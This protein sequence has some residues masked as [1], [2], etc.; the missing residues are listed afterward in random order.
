MST[1]K[2]SEHSV[3]DQLRLCRDHAIAHGWEIAK[4]YTDRAITGSTMILRPGVQQLMEAIRERQV[5][6]V[7]AESLDRLSRDQEDIAHIYKRIRHAD[8]RLVT[9]VEGEI[10]ELHI[11]LKGTMGAIFLKDLAQKT[12]RG[13]EGRALAGKSAG[14]KCYGYDVVR[15]L[16]EK[17]EPIRGDRA[18]NEEQ[19]AVIVRI[20]RDFVAGKSAKRIAQDLN[21]DGI[22]APTGDA[23]GHSTIN[24]NRRRGN[25]ILNNELY[26]GRQIWNRQRFLKHPDTGKREARPNPESEWVITEIPE[27]R[28]VPQELW[29]QVK[30]YQRELDEKPQFWQKQRPK[31]LLSG[32]CKCGHCGGG[33]SK[34]SA[35]HIGCSTARNKGTCDNRKS[36]HVGHLEERVLKALRSR[37]MEPER[38]R[39]FC[40]EYTAHMNRLRAEHNAALNGYRAE[41]ERNE[42]HIDKML[43]AIGNGLDPKKVKD[44]VNLLA[45]RQEELEALIADSKEAPILFHPNMGRHYANEVTKLVRSLNQEEHRSEAA[46]ILRSLIDHIELTFDSAT[47]ELV[48]DLHGD[49]A[50]ILQIASTG[51]IETR[52]EKGSMKNT[53]KAKRP[54]SR[55]NENAL[56]ASGS[57]A[58]GRSATGRNDHPI[59][60]AKLVA[61]AG[62][63]P[64]TF[65]L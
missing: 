51:N 38:C 9:L 63:E 45:A 39:V 26:I 18:I 55:A 35:Q 3:D 60:Q 12:H 32:L 20:F 34:I 31:R 53:Q 57:L 25:G 50:G 4:A 36:I 54:V 40:D 2:Q 58:G 17:G 46:H 47:H 11:G 10:G 64:A 15:K 30:S 22:P 14:G 5:D 16:D 49:L 62:F 56:A 8:M 48:V 28:I 19:A 44:K 41:Y 33:Y 59:M 7:L 42:Q 24:G 43:D 52:K 65:R 27:L 6:V 13:L 29:D 21:R 1:D 23:W 37:L 61:G